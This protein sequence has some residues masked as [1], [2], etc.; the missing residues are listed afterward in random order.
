MNGP[1]FFLKVLAEKLSLKPVLDVDGVRLMGPPIPR[2]L[3][4]AFAETPFTRVS[5]HEV[6]NGWADK[7][8]FSGRI[9]LIG[10]GGSE[11]DYFHVA[12]QPHRL[13][14]P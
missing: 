10:M 2:R 8:L 14:A 1:G 4:L 5:F 12:L 11:T 3:W 9:V 6:Y 7:K 13:H